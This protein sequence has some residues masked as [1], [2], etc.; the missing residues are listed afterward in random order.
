MK[1]DEVIDSVREMLDL[2]IPNTIEK[3]F[4]KIYGDDWKYLVSIPPPWNT[5]DLFQILKKHWLAVF[6]SILPRN[7]QQSINFGLDFLKKNTKINFEPSFQD[8]YYLCIYL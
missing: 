3:T 6:S 5:F 8:L 4:E 7:S 2:Y 1:K